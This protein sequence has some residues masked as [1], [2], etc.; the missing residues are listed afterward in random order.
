[1]LQKLLLD[2][3]RKRIKNKIHEM[4]QLWKLYYL[5]MILFFVSCSNERDI[6]TE[7]YSDGTLKRRMIKSY[8]EDGKDLIE[9][10]YES[11]QLKKTYFF[12]DGLQHGLEE[13]YRSDGSLELSINYYNGKL[14]GIYQIFHPNESL[15]EELSY[16]EGKKEGWLS[17]RDSNGY[18]LARNFFFQDS[19]LYKEIYQYEEGDVKSI[20]KSYYPIVQLEQDTIFSSEAFVF[21]AY[22]PLPDSF[23][24]AKTYFLKYDFIADPRVKIS[25][26]PYPDYSMP[27]DTLPSKK[28]YDILGI[29]GQVLYG[30]VIEGRDTNNFTTSYFFRK[31]YVKPAE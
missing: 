26:V 6:L 15:K 1:M 22:L 31:F 8:T 23:F 25:S 12:M 21:S 29:G 19:I 18:L 7:Y 20:Q 5:L 10:Y 27:L 13:W 2:R 14:N 30:Y 4:G 28:Q 17:L 9:E 3:R 11:G 16:R 24:E